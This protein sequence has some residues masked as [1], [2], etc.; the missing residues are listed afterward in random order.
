M[1]ELVGKKG[2]TQTLMQNCKIY[3]KPCEHFYSKYLSRDCSYQCNCVQEVDEKCEN[4]SVKMR[5]QKRS[6]WSEE[7]D[8]GDADGQVV[9]ALELGPA[10][11]HEL[12]PKNS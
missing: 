8:D 3:Q 7:N 2:Q 6:N 4:L 11:G 1:R 12:P 5:R 9:P 10:I